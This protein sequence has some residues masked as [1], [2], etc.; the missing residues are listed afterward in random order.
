MTSDRISYR[1][2]RKNIIILIDCIP[3]LVLPRRNFLFQSFIDDMPANLKWPDCKKY[4]I[5]YYLPN[6]ATIVTEYIDKAMWVN[7]LNYLN[8]EAL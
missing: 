1:Q 4:T 3:H 8:K 7:I 6:G 2:T 5:E